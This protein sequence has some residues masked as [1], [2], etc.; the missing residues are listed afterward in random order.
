MRERQ[1]WGIDTFWGGAEVV[2]RAED[3]QTVYLDVD[4]SGALGEPYADRH[5]NVPWPSGM[6]EIRVTTEDGECFVT[7]TPDEA[8]SLA[9][10]LWHAADEAEP[11]VPTVEYLA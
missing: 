7:A 9:W 6:V 8:R 4:E 10:S 3:E 11:L 5:N 1:V 2:V